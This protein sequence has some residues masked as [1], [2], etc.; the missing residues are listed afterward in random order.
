MFG[1]QW[2]RARRRVCRSG[3]SGAEHHCVQTSTTEIIK[4]QQQ[5]DAAL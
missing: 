5:Q 3:Q 4:L 2:R 1:A